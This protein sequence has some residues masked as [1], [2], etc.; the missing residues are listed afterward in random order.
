VLLSTHA[1]IEAVKR[2]GRPKSVPPFERLASVV[3]VSMTEAE[4]HG[5]PLAIRWR[6]REALFALQVYGR[7]HCLGRPRSRWVGGSLRAGV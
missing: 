1:T 4:G 6:R 5:A 2:L 7:S 3:S